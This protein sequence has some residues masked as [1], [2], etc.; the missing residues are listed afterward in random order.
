MDEPGVVRGTKGK[1]FA[2][3]DAQVRV[4]IRMLA[5]RQIESN[6]ILSSA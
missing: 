6:S 5:T 1:V 4:D 3:L 2:N